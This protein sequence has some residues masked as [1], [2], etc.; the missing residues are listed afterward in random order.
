ME[1]V[2][3]L[4]DRHP[5]FDIICAMK[6][7]D[8]LKKLEVLVAK[9]ESGELNLDE[10]IRAFEEGRTL[11][12]TCQEELQSIRLKIEKVTKGGEIEE[13]KI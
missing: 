13:L 3:E 2:L 5:F 8:N 7:E 10:M 11:V 4:P 6:F 1:V 12:K 9:M